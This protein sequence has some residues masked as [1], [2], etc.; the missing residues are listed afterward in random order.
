LHR[1]I[2]GKAC[3]RAVGSVWLGGGERDQGEKLPM[4]DSRLIQPANDYEAWLQQ[5]DQRELDATDVRSMWALRY[6]SRLNRVLAALAGLPPGSTVLEVGASQANTS[7]LA[8]ERGLR[9]V[10]LDRELRALVYAQRKY[11][12][13]EF[14]VVCGSAESL[15]LCDGSCAAVLALEILEH[16]PDPP[17]V[18]AEIRRVLRPGGLVVV[19]TPNAAHVHERLPS[20]AHRGEVTASA[21][22]DGEGHL[23]SF[24]LQELSELLSDNGFTVLEKGYQGSVVMADRLKINGLLRPEATQRLSRRLNHWPGA[25]Y[26][27]YGCF[28]VATATAKA[29]R[30]VSR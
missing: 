10:A 25:R 4:K 12:T 9:A 14:A 30:P 7:L 24:T 17:G 6:R 11:E 21:K 29:A 26:W 20:Y 3:K 13:G 18:L 2:S 27:S 19:T 22:A 5:F 8:A 23:F 15:P 1:A 28:V 16:V